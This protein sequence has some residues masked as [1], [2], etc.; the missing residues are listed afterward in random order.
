VDLSGKVAVVTG[1]ASGIGAEVVRLYVEAGARVVAVDRDPDLPDAAR[2][3]AGPRPEAVRPVVG[4][5][6]LEETAERYVAAAL[7]AFGSIDVMVNNAGIAVVK[8]IADHTPEDWDRVFG[9]NVKSIYWSARHVVPVMKRQGGG[10]FL[11]T[12]SISSV[13]GIAGQGAYAPSKGA[14]VQLTRQM[15]VEYG[16][17]GIRVNAVCPGTVDTPLLRKA[18]A[19]SGDPE[20]FL[21]GLSDAHPIGRIADAAEIAEFFLFLASDR[22]RFFT[23]AVLMIDGG[24]TAQ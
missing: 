7:D 21:R 5:V 8:A 20:G 15:A 24:F 18:A 4:D 10:L 3:L 17:D 13:A 23:G 2:R 12:G 19:D 16:K 1:A 14:V 11:N 9:V 6:A 22:A